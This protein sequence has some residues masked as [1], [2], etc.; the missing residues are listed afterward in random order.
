MALVLIAIVYEILNG[1]I[2]IEEDVLRVNLKYITI[3]FVNMAAS[4]NISEATEKS[5]PNWKITGD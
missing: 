5:I 2:A 4:S 1:R 3:P